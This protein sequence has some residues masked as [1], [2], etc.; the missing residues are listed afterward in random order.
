[1]ENPAI[2][3]NRIILFIGAIALFIMGFYLGKNYNGSNNEIPQSVILNSGPGLTKMQSVTEEF[4][5]A[6]NNGD[7]QGCADT[8]SEEALFMPP[9]LSS[10]Q[11]REAI[12]N[13]FENEVPKNVG[14]MKITEKVQEVIYFGDWATMQ[15]LGK[16]S[17]QKTDSTR[18][19]ISFKWAMLSKKNL[20]G[21]WESVWDIY[22]EV[23]K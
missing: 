11:G 3:I 12:K 10:I 17:I 21:K 19:N 2:N 13:H 16:I 5:I 8:Y 15:G 6:W 14:E 7:A 4:L 9:E 20:E 22:N 23:G 18:E 1:M